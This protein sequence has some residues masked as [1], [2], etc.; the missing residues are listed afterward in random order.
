MTTATKD[1]PANGAVP[2]EQE[3]ILLP[4]DKAEEFAIEAPKPPTPQQRA[5]AFVMA[6]EALKAQYGVVVIPYIKTYNN[7]AQVAS[8]EYAATENK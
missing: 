8:I 2:L 5:D 4:N 3:T 7:G 6:L 1:Q